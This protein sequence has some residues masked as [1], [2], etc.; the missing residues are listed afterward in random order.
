MIRLK[1]QEARILW[2]PRTGGN[3]IRGAL[4]K[5]GIEYELSIPQHQNRFV[6]SG[7]KLLT[8]VFVRNPLSWY[9]SAWAFYRKESWPTDSFH[10]KCR[11]FRF[12]IFIDRMLAEEPGYVTRLYEQYAGIPSKVQ[13][14]GHT[15]TLERDFCVFL[16]MLGIEADQSLLR[17]LGRPLQSDYSDAPGYSEDQIQRILVADKF[18]FESFGYT[19]VF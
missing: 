11:S 6:A 4:E 1:K 12:G 9:R 18:S 17:D 2:I 3:W 16:G 19:R 7:A 15:E 13:F 8:A 10:W 14:I 5:L